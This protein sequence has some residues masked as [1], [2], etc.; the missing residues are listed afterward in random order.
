MATWDDVR[1]FALAMP[2][3][4]ERVGGHRGTTQWLV[5]DKAFVWDRPLG[6]GDREALGEATPT[7]DVLAACVGDEASKAEYLAIGAPY[8][9]T[10][11]FDGHAIVLVDL[12]DL[13]DTELMELITDAWLHRAP[14]KLRK[15]WESGGA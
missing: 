5:R 14:A 8:F 13:D 4:I 12:A 9:T 15:A 1:A 7:G 2:E 6:K 11:H 10:P 3:V